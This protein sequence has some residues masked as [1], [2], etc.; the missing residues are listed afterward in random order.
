TSSQPTTDNIYT[1]ALPAV[2]STATVAGVTAS[3]SAGSDSGTLTTGW[4]VVGVAARVNATVNPGVVSTTPAARIVGVTARVNV[5]ALPGVA[6]PIAVVPIPAPSP[7][8]PPNPYRDAVRNG[9]VSWTYLVSASRGGVPV[10][11]ATDLRPTGGSITDTSKPGVRWT[12]SLELAPS[13]GLYE[14]LV[15]EGTRLSVTARATYLNRTSYDIPMG[16]YDVDSEQLAEGGGVLSL[17]AND[18]WAII[19]R[20]R[21]M[22]PASSTRGLT[23]VAQIIALIRGA[24]GVSEPVTVNTTAT[25]LVPSLTWDKDRAQTIIDLAQS[26]GAWVYFDRSGVATIDDIRTVGASADWLIDASPQGVLTSLTRQRSRSQTSNIVVVTSSASSGELFPVQYIWDNDPNSP[27][28]AGAGAGAGSVRPDPSTAGPFGQVPYFYDSP[29]LPTVD[30]A[31]KAGRAILART[32]GL[33]SQVSLG[34]VPNPA[35][36]ALDVIDVLPP[37]QRYDIARTLERHVVD[38]VTHPLLL[39]GS[40]EQTIAGRST[41]TDPY[42]EI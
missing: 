6:N 23:V 3:A 26:I 28:F 17:T 25:T 14:L 37:R 8:W 20:A 41:R 2:A 18:K 22:G 21:F 9:G 32:V 11:G 35:V 30:A 5:S 12:L 29:I 19:Q 38:T 27:T 39:S 42:T 4:T 33:A 36:Q 15:P 34:K 1:I 7:V 13:P 40:P 10:A 24:L 16:V 31:R